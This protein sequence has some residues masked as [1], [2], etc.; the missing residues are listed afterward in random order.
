M[1]KNVIILIIFIQIILMIFFKMSYFDF[2]SLLKN[3]YVGLLCLV[4]FFKFKK[5]D[6][7][8]NFRKYHKN[9]LLLLTIPIIYIFQYMFMPT[10]IGQ[11]IVALPLTIPGYYFIHLDKLQNEDTIYED[12][13]NV[14]DPNL[15]VGGNNLWYQYA[16]YQIGDYTYYIIF[17]SIS[18][19]DP[20]ISLWFHYSNNKTGEN[21]HYTEK[22]N[23][24]NYISKKNNK[25]LSATCNGNGFNFNY[26]VNNYKKKFYIKFKLLNQNLTIEYEGKIQTDY[27]Q[28][29]GRVFPFKLLKPIIP[30]IDGQ[31][32]LN[33]DESFNDQLIITKGMAIVNGKKYLNC[34]NWQDCQ[35]GTNTYFM[36][37]WLWI[38]QRS[39]N[40]CIYT[41]WYSDPEYYNSD[42]TLR[43]M[44]IYDIKNNKVILNGCSK[45]QPHYKML[46]GFN[47]C[48][49]DTKGTSVQD[50]NFEFN[51]NIKCQNFEA[52][53][54]SI[55]NSSIKVCDDVYMYERTDNNIDYGKMEK[56]MKVMEEIRYDEFSAKSI[57]KIK[58]NGKEYNEKAKVVID[59]MTW[60]YGWPTGYPKTNKSFFDPLFNL[61]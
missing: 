25:D 11:D 61:D 5:K 60:K 39:E 14:L 41:L 27:N 20:K 45:M 56:L 31:T 2:S 30:R 32:V 37:T 26:K 18:K 53:I 49:V 19:Y 6:I 13:L 33:S 4:I 35:N 8:W 1:I 34:S 17:T 55:A 36:T 58:Y 50:K 38:Y 59:S 57:F 7:L 43:A 47:H 48:S 10:Y 15:K 54:N 44:Y 3:T 16:H 42:E 12:Y 21:Y 51:C 46:T 23:K 29:V 28:F 24:H 9:Y 22:F 52:N 40:F